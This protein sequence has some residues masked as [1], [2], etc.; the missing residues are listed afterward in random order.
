M[1]SSETPGLLPKAQSKACGS[2]ARA[3]LLALLALL[4]LLVFTSV[5]FAAAPAGMARINGTVEAAKPF[6]A[7][8]VYLRNVDKRVA[9]MVF[10][11][12]GHFDATWLFPGNYDVQ[13]KAPGLLSDV[14]KISIG[15]GDMPA[16]DLVM[17]D[18]PVK[19]KVMTSIVCCGQNLRAEVK[20]EPYESVNPPGPGRAIAERTCFACHGESWLSAKP[21]NAQVW[22]ARIDHMAGKELFDR[23]ASD[24][25]EGHLPFRAPYA[26]FDQKDREILIKYLAENFGPEAEPRA[27]KTEKPVP[28]D[29]EQ[30]S[31]AMFI[32]YYVPVDPPGYGTADPENAK[33][34]F[35]AYRRRRTLQ[36]THFDADGNVWATDRS[37]PARLVKLD[38]RTAAWKEW[39]TPHPT[40]DIHELIVGRDGMIWMP[41]HANGPGERSSLLG[42][43]TKTEKFEYSIDMDPN[44]VIRGAFKWADSISIDSKNNMYVNWIQGGAISKFDAQTKQVVGVYLL[45]TYPAVP[46]GHVIDS[47]DNIFLA[48]WAKGSILKFNTRTNQW[49]E[50]TPPTFPSELRRLRVDADDNVWTGIYS[51]GSKRAG[52]LAKYDQKNDRWTEYEIPLQVSQPYDVYPDGNGGVWFPDTPTADRGALFAH[53]DEKS[54]TFTF[55]PKPQPDADVAKIQLARNGA[56]WGAPRGSL[57]APGLTVLYPDKSKI[58]SLAAGYKPGTLAGY[59]FK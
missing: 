48:M 51:A 57:T 36:D 19:D 9:Y 34:G 46:Y 41:E 49:T 12:H 7:A 8:Q 35:G 55:Y 42:F 20:L 10:T 6:T 50:L 43:N 30:L 15:P 33:K 24:Y 53:F 58:T 1:T 21:A 52:R 23:A 17:H 2:P 25:G 28:L 56:V 38:P 5:S 3:G 44:D 22:A 11:K 4:A 27:V 32:E 31:K 45:P 29:E 54:R 14:R 39:E 13:A 37:I 59:P 18:E 47:K 16:L 26:R 40:Y